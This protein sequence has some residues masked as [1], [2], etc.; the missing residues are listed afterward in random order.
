MGDLST[1]LR[2]PD[3]LVGF[4]GR[5]TAT[6]TLNDPWETSVAIARELG[7][8]ALNVIRYQVGNPTPVWFR[9]STH[10]RGGMEEYI[11]NDYMSVDPILVSWANG[12]MKDVD[13]ISLLQ[14]MNERDLSK[15]E[16][17]CFDH[18]LNHGQSDYITFRLRNSLDDTQEVL[19]VLACSAEVAEQFKANIDQLAII[20]NLFAVYNG[21]PTP[22]QPV[23][24]V[25]LLYEF[26]TPREKDVM[27]CLAKGL[28]NTQIADRLG[29]SEVTV[30]MHTT[31]ARKRMGATTR[32]QAIALALVRKLISA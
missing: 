17:E 26:L 4:L 16:L 12:T 15:K 29:I 19:V 25:P 30:R 23:G 22:N 14:Q 31:N 9:V 21:P 13:H 27:T 28:H 3:L 2:K 18:L 20:A 24:K 8:D 1:I 32:A 5:L 10:E 6:D 11:A 7:A